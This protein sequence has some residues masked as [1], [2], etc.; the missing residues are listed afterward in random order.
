MSASLLL[1]YIGAAI[2]VQLVVI[3]AVTVWR[4]RRL[5][6]V[7]SPL[8]APTPSGAWAGWREFRVARRAYEDQAHTV[9]SFHLEP[10]DGTPLPPFA[11]GQFL[12]FAVPVSA[13]HTLTRCYSLSDGPD[14]GGYR[15]SVK[16]VLAPAGRPELPAGACSNHLHD[17]L[18][19]GDVINAKAPAGHF[20]FDPDPSVPAVLI[21]GGIGI[22]PLLSMLRG[23][24]AA[25]ANRVVHLYYAVRQ[26]T[27]HAF[28][29][30]LEELARRHPG[31]RVRVVYSQ[32]GP[33]DT[34]GRD[35]HHAGHVDVDLLRRTLPAGRH[36][37]YVCG[38]A[39][40]MA[41]LLPALGQWGVPPDDLHHEAFGPTSARSV[42]ATSRADSPGGAPSFEVRFR[43]SARTLEWDGTDQ[44]LLEFA[45][46][47]AVP[48]DSGC[49]SGSC[50]TCE[51]KL[52]SG[53]V[54][55]AEAPDHEVTP[56]HCL[57]CVG[58]PA[59]HLVLEA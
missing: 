42:Q 15:I 37:F 40:M 41:S 17:R 20:V 44:N 34:V 5:A 35:F 24:L 32:P 16:R 52:T 53:T 19:I 49:R 3:T 14:P 51:I 13:D 59:G 7:R 2:V 29:G 10:V 47:H 38:P 46:R 30:E 23:G 33:D 43:K 12:T 4:R 25:E 39:A 27:E 22:T 57:L 55:Y 8:V 6:P 11:P 21:A 18:Q 31:L 28:R 58:R 9:C 48:V 50:G 45:E 1:A 56:G 26:G 36:R 54:R